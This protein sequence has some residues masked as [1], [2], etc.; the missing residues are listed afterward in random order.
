MALKAPPSPPVQATSWAGCYLGGNVGGA[1]SHTSAD[2]GSFVS[3]GFVDFAARQAVGQFPSFGLND[4]GAVGGAQIGCNWQPSATWVLGVEA[5]FDGSSVRKTTTF[6]Y[7]A[8][9]FDAN[10]ESAGQKIP[11]FG[12]VRARIGI[13]PS[14]AWLLYVTGGLAYARV[15]NSVSTT[16]V[17]D[18][19]P[20]V[21]VGVNSSNERVGWTVGGGAEWALSP[22]W[23]V[24]AEY[25][26]VELGHETLN[27]N[28]A[29]LAAGAGNAINYSFRER[30]DVARVGLN[31][32]FNATSR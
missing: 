31:F 4:G 6:A 8:V 27:L 22:A 16:G 20:G 5:D 9:G 30:F 14:A 7:P 3:T 18:G 2:P 21:T 15:E 1:W 10:S 32:H 19:F 11:W 12:T 13:T 29:V 26:H 28:Y 23:S 24:K 25:L 17:P